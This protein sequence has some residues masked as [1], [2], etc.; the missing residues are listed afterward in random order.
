MDYKFPDKRISIKPKLSKQRPVLLDTDND[1]YWSLK[2]SDNTS[3]N[4]VKIL[5]FKQQTVTPK[6][7]RNRNTR[8]KTVIPVRRI[9]SVMDDYKMS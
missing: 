5:K 2:P 8:P 3:R 1:A 6:H 4:L 9:S 7:L